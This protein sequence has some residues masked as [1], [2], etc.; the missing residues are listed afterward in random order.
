[1]T[2]NSLLVAGCAILAFSP[3]A[4]LFFLLCYSKAHLIII[5]TTSAFA[6]LISSL[7]SSLL[8]LPFSL[9]GSWT[10][11]GKAALLVIPAVICQAACRCGFVVLYHRVEGAISASI[12][13]HERRQEEQE[14][15]AASERQAA[16]TTT[17]TTNNNSNR[18]S[19]SSSNSNS[20]RNHLETRRLRL[21][22]NDWSCGIAAGIG[23]SGM[24]ALMLYGTLLASEAASQ[25][26][27]YQR[28]CPGIPTLANSAL[29]TFFFSILDIFL[30]LIVFYGMRRRR[31]KR[32]VASTSIDA[33]AVTTGDTNAPKRSANMAL[34]ASFVLH[35]LA[36]FTTTAN[37]LQGG[38]KIALPF[39]A[40]TV[41]AAGAYL[42]FVIGLDKFLPKSQRL[43]YHQAI[44]QD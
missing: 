37:S 43:M 3:V 2:N 38:C 44:H 13:L 29:N 25:G 31:Y 36:G 24:H 32:H 20:N 21:E 40:A 12:R 14:A 1:M 11:A 16:T 35:L 23:Y 39:L 15:E 27:L 17:A 5:V 18:N 41:L 30:M 7:L 9:T 26:T 22:L 42:Y 8:W 33:V 4:F 34:L 6:Y 10:G 28:S 19:N